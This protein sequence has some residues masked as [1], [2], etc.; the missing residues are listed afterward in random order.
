VLYT[1]QT[2]DSYV[3]YCAQIKLQTIRLCAVHRSN[4]RLLCCVLCT[5]QTADC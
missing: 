5:D 1:D 4:C 2:V 3:V